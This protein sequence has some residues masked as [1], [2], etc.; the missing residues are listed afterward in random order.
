MMVAPVLGGIPSP[1]HSR[2]RAALGK[3]MLG[4]VRVEGR[5]GLMRRL[6]AIVRI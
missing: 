1:V 2:G 4:R 6:L 5:L 3:V